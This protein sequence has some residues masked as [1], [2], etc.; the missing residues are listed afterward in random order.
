MLGPKGSAN[1]LSRSL[2]TD[3][4][5]DLG[6][7]TFE[8]EGESEPASPTVR[9]RT[10]EAED[11]AGT[12]GS[13]AG[14]LSTDLDLDLGATTFEN[15]GEP[16]PASPTVRART[17]EAEDGA[18]TGG[19]A[20]GQL[21]L[22]DDSMLQDLV[23]AFEA[24]DID[25]NGYLDAHE[26]LAVIR[27]LGGAA[28]AQ[29]LDIEIM[30]RLIQQ[31]WEELKR[32]ESS[33]S[34]VDQRLA[35]DLIDVQSNFV[36]RK[37]AGAA[38]AGRKSVTTAGHAGLMTATVLKKGVQR[39]TAIGGPAC[40]SSENKQMPGAEETLDYAMFVHLLTSGRASQFMGDS[41]DDWQDHAHQLRLLK[42]AWNTA[43]LDGDG[44]LTLQEMREVGA[45][46]LGH[47]T[48]A[49]FSAF[50]DLLKPSP[51]AECLTY[52]DFLNGMAKAELHPIFAGKLE[53]LK[54]NQLMTVLVDV[55]VMQKEEKMMLKSLSFAERLG[56]SVLKRKAMRSASHDADEAAVLARVTQG[57]VHLLTD[58]QRRKV[59]ANHRSMIL[60]GC[61]FG[62]VSS[63]CTALSENLATYHLNTNGFQN[64]DTGEP[65]SEE[66]VKQFA[67]IVLCALL[68]CSIVE[69]CL[70]YLYALRHA[71]QTA[72]AAGLKLTP[73]NRDRTN[74]AKFLVQAALEMAHHNDPVHGV[75]PLKD[76]GEQGRC[77]VV[78]FLVL[79][80]AKIALTSFVLKI[81]LKRL[82][83]R[84]AAKYAVP[85]MAVPAT[86]LWNSLIAHGVMKQ[87]K[88]RS[89][90]ISAAVELFDSI[91]NS[92]PPTTANAAAETAQAGRSDHS[93]GGGKTSPS[94]PRSIEKSGLSPLLKIQLLR[95]IGVVIV[96]RQRL[97]PTQEV[98]L[99]HAVHTLHMSN[100]V[101]HTS[102]YVDSEADFLDHIGELSPH[103][104]AQCLQVFV[105]TVILDGG[106]SSVEKKL[107]KRLCAAVDE[108][109][110]RPHVTYIQHC[111]QRLRNT[112]PVTE[113]DLRHCVYWAA[114]DGAHELSCG[115]YFSECLHKIFSICT[116]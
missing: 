21:L 6:A 12:G 4:D 52:L 9:A 28:R 80:K 100:E 50:W 90:G 23:F 65:S 72:L 7:T 96:K 49:E 116:C 25:G 44:E 51:E 59:R 87:A 46:L 13:A 71:M 94:S 102:G 84:D 41:Q 57:T 76:S 92:R 15:E 93:G 36:R 107:Y 89:V 17:F 1:P 114:E 56:V 24:C 91:L 108:Q 98:L 40:P 88:L 103:E 99:K 2:S 82:V 115:Y 8:N 58:A 26:L 3:L 54:P 38:A 47:M 35:Q 112:Q 30:R 70:L 78:F 11:G 81:A 113:S 109:F 20:A 110:A 85:Y 86:M 27:V 53:F 39:V 68:V 83:S 43:D 37:A 66:E 79:Y 22:F 60:Y 74:I 105:L 111:A 48:S 97:Y 77:L 31:E 106:F 33:G 69:I 104:Q 73:L 14:P 67:A 16:E 19:S 10:F 34:V 62:F 95:A 64:P 63:V 42:H 55:P 5:L 18:G 61:L 29:T 32:R 101:D 75:D 45:T